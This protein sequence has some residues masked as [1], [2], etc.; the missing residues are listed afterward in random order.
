MQRMRTMK[1]LKQK[2]ECKFLLT[3]RKT[4]EIAQNNG[5]E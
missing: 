3:E 4:H 1:L 2:S 5:E